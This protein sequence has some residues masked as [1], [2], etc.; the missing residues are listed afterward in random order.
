ML[1]GPFTLMRCGAAAQP[2]VML[3]GGNGAPTGKAEVWFLSAH[4]LA[5]V[6]RDESGE[7]IGD[8][9]GLVVLMQ[10]VVGPGLSSGSN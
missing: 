2:A 7:G 6:V 10:V 9:P 5:A 3:A 1:H 8:E 4:G